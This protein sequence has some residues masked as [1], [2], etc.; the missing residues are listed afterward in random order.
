MLEAEYYR[1][2]NQ[3]VRQGGI[4]PENLEEYFSYGLFVG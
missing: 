2:F 4:A 1:K 3:E